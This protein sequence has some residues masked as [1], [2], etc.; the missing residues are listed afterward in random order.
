MP[1]Y[2]KENEYELGAEARPTIVVGD[3][4]LSIRESIFNTAALN[5]PARPLPKPQPKFEERLLPKV[6]GV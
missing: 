1:E 5:N 6:L 4:Y 3:K 2:Y